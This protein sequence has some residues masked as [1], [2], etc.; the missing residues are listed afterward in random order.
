MMIGRGW[1][2]FWHVCLCVCVWTAFSPRVIVIPISLRSAVAAASFLLRCVPPFLSLLSSFFPLSSSFTRLPFCC[3]CFCCWDTDHYTALLDRPWAHIHVYSFALSPSPFSISLSHPLCQ[4]KMS[5]EEETL[6]NGWDTCC[7]VGCCL[8][9]LCVMLRK[10]DCVCS[11]CET[12]QCGKT[13]SLYYSSSSALFCQHSE[14][15]HHIITA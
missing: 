11:S 2:G 15:S 12:Q 5:E 9:L 14:L 4:M 6:S 3:C 13:C 10:C 8:L 7:T 1:T